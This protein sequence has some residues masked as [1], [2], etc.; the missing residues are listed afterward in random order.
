[1][2]DDRMADVRHAAVV[3][4]AELINYFAREGT[5]EQLEEVIAKCDSIHSAR[6]YSKR[7][8]Y[9]K[10]CQACSLRIVSTI[11]DD[12]FL[13]K[14]LSYAD[15]RIANVRFT[16]ARLLA[17]DLLKNE[18]YVSREDVNA[19]VMKLRNDKEDV[20]VKRFFA[21]EAE[22]EAF[23]QEQQGAIVEEAPPAQPEADSS[24]DS[25]DYSSDESEEESTIKNQMTET[26]DT[27]NKENNEISNN[28]NASIP[29]EQKYEQ[30]PEH[31]KDKEKEKEKK[32]KDKKHKH[33]DKKKKK[34][35]EENRNT[36]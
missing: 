36:H 5:P 33:K 26:P 1:L 12:R 19:C 24:E 21:T 32:G 8:L 30:T 20:E 28:P 15:D 18:K 29:T 31:E 27:N 23:L 7:L 14:L 13:P 25:G 35:R 9:V 3:P 17:T 16:L 22:I 4:I 6:T 11:F 10:L 2:C 34:R